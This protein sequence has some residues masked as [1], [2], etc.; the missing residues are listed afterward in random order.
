MKIW[1]HCVTASPEGGETPIADSRAVY[2]RIPARIREL[3]EPGILYVRNFGEM[4]VPGRRSSTPKAA[5]RSRPSAAM[6][7][8][9][10]SGRR[11]TACARASCA[12]PWKATPSRARW[13]GSTR[14]TCSTSRRASPRSARCWRRVYGIEN[15]PRNTFFA[16]GSTIGDIFAE[17][18]AALD[19]ETVSFPWEQGDVLMLDNMLVAHAA[20]PSRG[21]ARSSS[22]WPSRAAIWTVSENPGGS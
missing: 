2:R 7:A 15:L 10:G 20:R 3:F 12:R 1:F 4:D 9:T 8:W 16:D 13:S 11:T 5:P 19:A 22:P 6:R 17:V 14:P 18:R 21:R